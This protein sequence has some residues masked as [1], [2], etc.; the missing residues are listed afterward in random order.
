VLKRN[1]CGFAKEIQVKNS[2][3]FGK[4]AIWRFGAAPLDKIQKSSGGKINET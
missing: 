2:F 1:K 4:I 3:D